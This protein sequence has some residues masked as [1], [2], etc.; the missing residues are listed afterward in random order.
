L[1]QPLR[2]FDCNCQVGRFSAPE[3]GQPTEA[4]SVGA[5]LKRAGVSR[6]LCFSSLANEY[7]VAAGNLAVSEAAS[8]A[9]WMEPCWVA[10]PHHT[11]EVPPPGDLLS[12]MGRHGVRAVRLFPALQ[13]W[14]LTDYG[15]GE[16]LAALEAAR[17]PALLDFDQTSWDQVHQL[18][19]SHPGLPLVIL[20]PGYRIDRAVYPLLELHPNLRLDIG[21][22]QVHRGIEEISRRFGPDRLLFGTGLPFI[23]PGAAVAMV[24]YA[25]LPPEQKQ[26]I[27]AGN[28]ESLLEQVSR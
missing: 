14:L 12:E 26:A 16:L 10:M 7:S 21:G 22:Y 8:K 15:A 28:L 24:T 18:C 4:G 17:I 3:P 13:G 11:G 19:S 6:A 2:F 9:E 25:D 1:D 23:D 5:A 20:R 27:A